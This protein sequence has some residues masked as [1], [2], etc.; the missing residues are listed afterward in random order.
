MLILVSC[1]LGSF[2]IAFHI[3]L[4]FRFIVAIVLVIVISDFHLLIPTISDCRMEL[5]LTFD[6]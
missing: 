5:S 6:L 2:V 1:F 4:S 3:S